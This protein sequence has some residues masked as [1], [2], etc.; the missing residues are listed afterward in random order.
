LQ[1]PADRTS[2][3]AS[4]SFHRKLNT[5]NVSLSLDRGGTFLAEPHDKFQPLAS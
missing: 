5:E 2:D 3:S 1:M 4:A